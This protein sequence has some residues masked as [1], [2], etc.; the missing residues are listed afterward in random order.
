LKASKIS[1]I[2]SYLNGKTFEQISKENHISKGGVF[3]TI[4]DWKDRISVPDIE[5]LRD[6]SVMVKKSGLTIEQCAQGF[7][8]IQILS[9]FGIS[10]ELEDKYRFAFDDSSHVEYS[11]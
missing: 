6:F 5:V 11:P 4:R 3:N 2:E 9:T 8:C 1:V 7:R 10:D